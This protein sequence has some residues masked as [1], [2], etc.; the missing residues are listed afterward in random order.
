MNN[1]TLMGRVCADIEVKSTQSGVSVA[2]FSLAVDR[3]Y[4]PQGQERQTDFITCVAWR[5]NAE[6][7]AKWFRKGDML[8][9]TGEINTRKYTDK[10][11]NNRTAT[12]VVIDNAYFCGNKNSNAAAPAAPVADVVPF[13]VGTEIPDDDDLPF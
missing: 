1:V 10:D 4:T 3:R 8:A 7:V 13:P 6:F 2:S 5:H 12:E 11:G 9:V